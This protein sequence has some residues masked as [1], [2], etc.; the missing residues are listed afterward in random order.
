MEGFIKQI[1]QI[2]NKQVQYNTFDVTNLWKE[3]L[4]SPNIENLIFFFKQRTLINKGVFSQINNKKPKKRKWSK[5]GQ[6]FF[7]NISI[8]TFFQELIEKKN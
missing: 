7:F 6:K 8:L 4:F 3:L 1:N 5:T 2:K